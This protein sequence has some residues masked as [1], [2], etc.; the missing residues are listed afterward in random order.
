MGCPADSRGF[1]LFDPGS[2]QHGDAHEAPPPAGRM[3]S[4]RGGYSAGGLSA[5]PGMG[6]T[7]EVQLNMP[8]DFD[9][10]DEARPHIIYTIPHF[11]SST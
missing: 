7:G 6:G 5:R 8:N 3:A 1:F 2:R 4:Y 11:L 10:D 9:I